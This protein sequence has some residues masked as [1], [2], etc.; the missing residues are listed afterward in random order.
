MSHLST[1]GIAPVKV[2]N[3]SMST[4][5]S[6]SG[7]VPCDHHSIACR[8]WHEYVDSQGP[9]FVAPDLAIAFN[10]GISEVD[11]DLWKPTIERLIE[12]NI[13]SAFTVGFHLL[14][15][16][17]DGGLTIILSYDSGLQ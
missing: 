15:V 11:K 8:T 13:P 10:G 9:K 17:A 5:L 2:A 6:E 4:F 1:E 3:E 14:L 7:A 16:H 12:M